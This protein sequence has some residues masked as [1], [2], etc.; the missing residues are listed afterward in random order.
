MF[1]I[2]RSSK[3]RA[4]PLPGDRAVMQTG[5]VTLLTTLTWK[6]TQRGAFGSERRWA[7]VAKNHP[8]KTAEKAGLAWLSS[9]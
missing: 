4:D 6:G 2:A 9:G 1:S 3:E 5:A 8:D 7:V